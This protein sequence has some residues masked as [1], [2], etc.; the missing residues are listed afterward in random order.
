MQ[1][2]KKPYYNIP[3]DNPFIRCDYGVSN[4]PDSEQDE[5]YVHLFRTIDLLEH[6]LVIRNVNRLYIS[7]VNNEIREKL[8]LIK[9][10]STT[11]FDINYSV[12][13]GFHE[14]KQHYYTDKDELAKINV[15]EDVYIL[16]EYYT[17]YRT[18]YQQFILYYAKCIRKIDNYVEW[19]TSGQASCH[20]SILKNYIR[21]QKFKK[22]IR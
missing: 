15:G 19:Y 20:D 21:T 17:S 10:L 3:T 2:S 6:Q 8:G 12:L 7:L 5:P 13:D 4:R 22:L 16:R 18:E 1:S 14:I 9:R 11:F